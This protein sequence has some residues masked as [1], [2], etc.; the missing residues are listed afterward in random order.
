MNLT[1]FMSLTP[2]SI[3]K[4][5]VEL[6]QQNLELARL[7]ARQPAHRKQTRVIRS[8]SVLFLSAGILLLTVLIFVGH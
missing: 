6:T 7:Q 8:K 5:L 2:P 1:F 3:D 4:R